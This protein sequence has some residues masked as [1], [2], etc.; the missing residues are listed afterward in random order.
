VGVEN[1]RMFG[2]LGLGVGVRLGGVGVSRTGGGKVGVGSI[3]GI[4]VLI[5][6]VGVGRP[7][8]VDPPAQR[9]NASSLEP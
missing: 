2:P 5:G 1:P 7:G 6:G 9:L 3:P 4:Q 8:G